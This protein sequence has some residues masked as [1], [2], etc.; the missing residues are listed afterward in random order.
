MIQKQIRALQY[1]QPVIINYTS[2]IIPDA[3]SGKLISITLTGNLTL[4]SPI[5]AVDGQTNIWEFIQD[6]TGS[7]TL[8]LGSA[9]AFG[10][11]ISSA[12]LTTTAGA[13]DFMGTIYKQSTGK[14]YVV[15]FANGY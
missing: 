8:T 6:G 12:T 1:V 2:T 13:R 4:S 3:S 10:V 7:R 5:N 11:G 9:F 15:A 14:F